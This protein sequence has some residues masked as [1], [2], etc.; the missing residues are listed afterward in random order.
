MTNKLELKSS[1]EVI[2]TVDVED[3]E[4]IFYCKPTDP[5][6]LTILM[7][8]GKKLYC[9]EV[10]PVDSLQKEPKKCMYTN[11]HYTDED[12]K[13]LCEDCEERCEYSK[14]E[15]PVSEQNLSNIQRIGKNWKEEPVNEKDKLRALSD[16]KQH[17][18]WLDDADALEEPI[19]KEL[20][21]FIK[22]HGPMATLEK[23][24]AHFAEW[25]K[26]HSNLSVSEDLEEAAIEY[27]GG[28]KGSDARVRTGFIMGANWQ[29]QKG[30]ISAK[31]LDKAAKEWLIPQLDKS[32]ANYG[33]RKMMELTRFDGYA[34]LDAIE[35]GANWMLNKITKQDK[36]KED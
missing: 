20:D 24:A 27:C 32:Y 26:K 18:G 13:V 36:N 5:D 6:I 35:F 15:E 14:K 7:K 25:G 2:Y 21:R 12:R 11:E 16:G 33:E 4:S 17:L 22:E 19:N 23:C 3:V 10:C 9:D 8:D 31:D 29:K 1:H 30:A 34:M 28:N